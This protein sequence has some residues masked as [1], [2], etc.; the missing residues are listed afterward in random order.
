MSV[1]EAGGLAVAMKLTGQDGDDEERF[2]GGAPGA[3]PNNVRLR[4]KRDVP[5]RLE[6][7]NCV[8]ASCGGLGGGARLGF[9]R[10][11]GHHG[12]S[13][14]IGLRETVSMAS[15]AVASPS[16]VRITTTITHI[17]LVWEGIGMGIRIGIGV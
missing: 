17:L 9:S 5:R 12:G 14:H 8:I 16:A 6:Q 13:L 3:S 10:G 11:G 4:G 15:T 2:S 1:V 7:R